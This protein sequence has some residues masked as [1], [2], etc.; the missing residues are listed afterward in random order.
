M[1][2]IETLLNTYRWI[3]GTD[4]EK[5]RV[6]T[7]FFAGQHTKNLYVKNVSS[8]SV[9]LTLLASFLYIYMV[10]GPRWSDQGAGTKNTRRCGVGFPK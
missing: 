5:T 4:K 10:Q 8:V 3:Q 6:Q 2:N 7:Q 9:S 1:W